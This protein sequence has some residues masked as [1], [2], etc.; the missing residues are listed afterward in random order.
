[1]RFSP[2]TVCVLVLTVLIYGSVCSGEVIDL[3]DRLELL[4]DDH[5]A[6][7]KAIHTALMVVS[8][9]AAMWVWRTRTR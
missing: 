4:L 1:M 5:D 9:S 2:L 6:A 3:G 8:I 7:F